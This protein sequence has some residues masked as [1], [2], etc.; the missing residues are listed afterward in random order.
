[1]NGEQ[2]GA[3]GSKDEAIANAWRLLRSD[4]L[5]AERQA[6]EVIAGDEDD[7]DAHTILGVALRRRGNLAEA[8]QA[9]AR[10][11]KLASLQPELFKAA[12][13]LSENR[14]SAAEGDVRSYIVNHP[15]DAVA[16]RIL[17]EIAARTGHFDTADEMLERALALAPD[18]ARAKSLR[19]AT[20]RLRNRLSNGPKGHRG[21]IAVSEDSEDQ[22]GVA[23]TY[24][25]AI[26]L[27]E[28]ALAL[29]PDRP[30]NWVSYGHVLRTLGR[31]AEAI[32]A[33][34]RAI[35]VEPTFGD[36]WWAIADLK[37]DAFAPGDVATMLS[38]LDT[39]DLPSSQSV[40]LHFAVARALEQDG[41][42]ARAFEHYAVGND[43]RFAEKPFDRSAVTRHVDQSI[44][45][46]DAEFFARREGAGFPADDPIF[47]VGMPRAGSTLIEQILASHP[48]IE[49]TMELIDIGALANHLGG[50]ADAGLED[51][52]Y[53]DKL[54]SLDRAEL[55]KLGQS[56]IWSSGLR[57]TTER[58]FFTD[59]MPNNWLHIG[60][61]MAILPNAAIIDARRHPL[62]CG[63]SN[64]KQF[65][66]AGQAFTY[67]LRDIGSF[68]SDYVRMMRHFDAVRPGKIHRVFH[69][70]LVED[71]EAE[72]RRLLEYL[73][74]PF[75][76]ACLK[77][78]ESK[79]PVRTASSEQVRRPVNRSGMGK[80]KAFDPWLGELRESLGPVLKTYPDVPDAD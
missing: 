77:F 10:A 13:A 35:D 15:H 20:R 69:E 70:R 9:E 63:L 2:A 46:F 64:F 45:T 76:P 18:Y 65:F 19:S 24:T 23:S 66:A 61:I 49:S 17:A 80:W 51:S 8:R 60:L 29:H 39:P 72:V 55:T 28:D 71:P 6:R 52:P 54:A 26:E 57:R 48:Q 30:Q 5:L 67:N 74:L 22:A 1:M 53:I 56:Y 31:Q 38:L 21:A 4:P 73:H 25:D 37:S 58:P 42:F 27:Y 12:I 47:I 79:R 7:P 50:R 59:K 36:A 32:A 3:V 62:D 34:H 44:A 16:L 11:I 41:D 78:H 68:Y 43:A 75:D 40:P 14:L 33:Y